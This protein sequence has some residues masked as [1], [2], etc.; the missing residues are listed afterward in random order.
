M[1][2]ALSSEGHDGDFA[3]FLFG[4]NG[5]PPQRMDALNVQFSIEDERMGIDW[6]LLAPLNIENQTRFVAFLEGNA[7]SVQQRQV[8][9]VGSLR[10]EGE[11]L[12]G[13]LRELL[14]TEFGV[15]PDQTLELV[16]SGFE[17]DAT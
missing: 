7:R 17:W 15:G 8:N 4:E 1:L 6:V 5:Q 14:Q 2:A 10:V 9:G 11:G 13:L 12:A 3:V 16:A